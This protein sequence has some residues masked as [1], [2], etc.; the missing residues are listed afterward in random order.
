MPQKLACLLGALAFALAWTPAVLA[1]DAPAADPSS[2]NTMKI[3]LAGDSTVTDD[4]GWGGWFARSFEPQAEVTNLSRG[5]RSSKS[6]LAEGRWAQVLELN[7]D[8]VLIQFGHNDEPGHGPERETQPREGYRQNLIRYVEEARAAGAMPVLVTPIS[9]RQWQGNG[10]I[11]SSLAEYAQVVREIAANHHVPMI[12]LHDRSLE[13]Y[14]SLGEDGCNKWIAP[15]KNNGTAFDG[16]HLNEMGGRL[17]GALVADEL[18]RVVP[19]LASYYDAFDG[20]P[21]PGRDVAPHDPENLPTDVAPATLGSDRTITVAADGSGDYAT[22]QE[23]IMAAPDDSDARTTIHIRPGVYY[24]Q[25]VVPGSKRNLTFLGDGADTTIL[26]YGLDVGDP[27]PPGV[28]KFFNGTGTVIA[29]DGFHARHITFRNTAGDHGQALAVRVQGDRAIFQNCRLLG[30]QDTLLAHSNRQYFKDC[31]IEGRVDFIFGG[32]Q[33][34]FDGCEIRSKNGGYV[35]AASTDEHQPFGYV[36]LGCKLTSND[37]E[38]TYLGR[39]WRDYA[40]VTFINCDMADHIR[41]EGWHNWGRPEKEKTA[42]YSEFNSNGLGA[43]PDQRVSWSRQLTRA[44]ADAITIEKV[45]AGD[46]GWNPLAE[47]ER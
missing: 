33:A 8:V 13:V 2:D 18:R 6:F 36:F 9:R 46:D 39:P 40:S 14:Y 27:M 32:S 17:F 43:T 37:G 21:T 47:L 28:S 19:R 7:P 26:T 31:Y 45:L 23:A 4:A 20:I 44:E 16:T 35:T 11:E 34:V 3:V 24:G 41:P 10:R 38:P 15:T 5:G 1:Q 29:A 12:N 22:V 25:F 42:R 30:W